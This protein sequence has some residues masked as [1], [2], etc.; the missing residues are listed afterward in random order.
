ML[1]INFF[2]LFYFVLLQ[3]YS[4]YDK[5]FVD[6]KS[7]ILKGENYSIVRMSRE[8]GKIKVKYFAARDKRTGKSVPNR[9]LEWSRNKNIIAFSSG[10]YMTNLNSSIADPK[11]ICVD[12]G[13]VINRNLENYDGLVLVYATG[14]MV[15]TDIKDGDLLLNHSLNST[16][17]EKID[18]INDM[19]ASYKLLNWAENERATVF[20]THLFVYKNNLKIAENSS[21]TIAKRRFFAACRGED[22]K[23]YYYIINLPNES[24]LLEGVKKAK[25]YLQEME[26]VQEVVYLINLDT[27]AQNIFQV[28][29]AK[30]NEINNKNFKGELPVNSAANLLVFYYE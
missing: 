3:S 9:F 28:Y 8:S 25:S 16:K 12:A 18:L 10:T 7:T 19:S 4:Q 21:K 29:D 23:I 15:A 11:G 27:G 30:G 2:L 24:T 26:G 6:I 17:Q 1:K 20:Q 14:G 22:K 13:I 5:N